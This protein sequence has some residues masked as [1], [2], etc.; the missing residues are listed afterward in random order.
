MYKLMEIIEY[1]LRVSTRQN[2]ATLGRYRKDRQQNLVQIRAFGS[3]IIQTKAYIS[4]NYRAVF[5]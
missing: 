4:F 2:Q 3:V 5:I 1:F